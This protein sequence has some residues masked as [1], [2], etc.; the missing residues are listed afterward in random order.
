MKILLSTVNY[1]HK[2]GIFH[3]DL[4]GENIVL[5]EKNN[6]NSLKLIDFALAT[7]NEEG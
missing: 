7:Y 5:A 2:Q 3:R 4:K 1:L 6:L